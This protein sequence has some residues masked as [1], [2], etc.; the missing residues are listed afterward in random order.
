MKK[1]FDER[2]FST[3]KSFDATISRNA[4][5]ARGGSTGLLQEKLDHKLVFQEL[6]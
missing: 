3:E 2:M 1:F 6:L 4:R 5:G